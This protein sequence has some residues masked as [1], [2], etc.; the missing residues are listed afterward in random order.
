MYIYII[1]NF[2]GVVQNTNPEN[3]TLQLSHYNSIISNTTTVGDTITSNRKIGDNSKLLLAQLLDCLNFEMKS[4]NK[5][6]WDFFDNSLMQNLLQVGL[7]CHF[8][9]ALKNN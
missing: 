8:F 7:L 6:K 5:P 9:F 1:V 4:I 2:L 3:S